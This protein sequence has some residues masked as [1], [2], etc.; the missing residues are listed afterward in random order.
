V[1]ELRDKD[2]ISTEN[3]MQMVARLIRAGERGIHNHPGERKKKGS[4]K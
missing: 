1:D 3:H 4:R 2:N